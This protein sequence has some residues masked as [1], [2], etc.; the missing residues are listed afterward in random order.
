MSRNLRQPSNPNGSLRSILSAA[1]GNQS[2]VP[3]I[4]LRHSP[5]HRQR[6]PAT[7]VAPLRSQ[8]LPEVRCFRRFYPDKSRFPFSAYGYLDRSL[9]PLTKSGFQSYPEYGLTDDF[10]SCIPAS[11]FQKDCSLIIRLPATLEPQ[12]PYTRPV[13]F[14]DTDP[15]FRSFGGSLPV[16]LTI[17]S[18]HRSATG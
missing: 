7:W 1:S 10:S 6:P 9:Q 17:R 8:P 4:T 12:C 3:E 2:T 14:P 13:S 18:R 11:V 15:G 16:S 5:C